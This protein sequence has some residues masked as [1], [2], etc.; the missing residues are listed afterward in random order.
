MSEP[1]NAEEWRALG[2]K[3]KYDNNLPKAL[4]ALKW[5]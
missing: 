4:E 1:K 3:L 5:R 2:N